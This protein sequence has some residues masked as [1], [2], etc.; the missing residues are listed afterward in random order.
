MSRG[1]NRLLDGFKTPR[2]CVRPWSEMLSDNAKKDQLFDAL[3]EMLTPDALADLPPAMQLKPATGAILDWVADRQSES[4]VYT[5]QTRGANT[6][7]GLLIL[8]ASLPGTATPE[9]HLGY[10]FSQNAWGNGYA[11]ELVMGLVRALSPQAPLRIIGGV[12][13]GNHA[14]ARVFIKAGFGIQ[15]SQTS[16]DTDFYAITLPHE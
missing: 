1:E 11:T 7:A 15:P 12:T 2:L 9:L 8:A 6:V 13:R 3:R 16:G 5:V 4:D 10:L 14:S